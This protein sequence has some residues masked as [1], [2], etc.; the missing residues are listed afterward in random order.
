MKSVKLTKDL[1]E[2]ILNN[3]RIAFLQE[4]YKRLGYKDRDQVETLLIDA[5]QK[6]GI[7]LWNRTY[8][9][10]ETQRLLKDIPKDL[11]SGCTS[12]R[13]NILT[14]GYYYYEMPK[15][16]PTKPSGADLTM[17]K[18]EY[19]DL[20]TKHGIDKLKNDQESAG[21][22][23]NEFMATVKGIFESANT[24]KQLIDLW[25]EV[26]EFIPQNLQDPSTIRLPMVCTTQLNSS[27][28]L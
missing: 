2:T 20:L 17:D 12:F 27:L 7:E 16:Y 11:L 1:K 5:E 19:E 6:L 24:T 15:G 18:H 14:G 22:K 26:I 25:P 10:T 9:G 3:I 4:H 21:K 13:V 23:A 28:G 8:G